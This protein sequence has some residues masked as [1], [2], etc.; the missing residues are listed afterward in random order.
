M[1]RYNRVKLKMVEKG[2]GLDSEV[3]SSQYQFQ[4]LTLRTFQENTKK[5][6]M[7]PDTFS[8]EKGQ[9]REGNST[10]YNV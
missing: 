4:M 7:E 9:L 3:I 10:V 6:S 1:G 5:Y 2:Q 8:L